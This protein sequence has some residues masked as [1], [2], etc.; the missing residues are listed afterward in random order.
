[1]PATKGKGQCLTGR[2]IG[3]GGRRSGSKS[4]TRLDLLLGAHA[5]RFC[6]GDRQR[7]RRQNTDPQGGVL[8]CAFVLLMTLPVARSGRIPWAQWRRWPVARSSTRSPSAA[9][10]GV[11][12][13]SRRWR[14]SCIRSV[15]VAG[16]APRW[17]ERRSRSSR[18]SLRVLAILSS[19]TA[20]SPGGSVLILALWG[21]GRLVYSRDGMARCSKPG[22]RSCTCSATAPPGLR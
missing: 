15:R 13:H 9:M 4:L 5:E 20:F 14:W 8:A 18:R 19:N 10:F 7:H 2:R 16:C 1:M 17:S 21:V 11:E 6:C 12:L 3:F 22:L